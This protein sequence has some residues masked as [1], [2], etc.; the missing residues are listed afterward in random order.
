MDEMFIV[1][2]KL[3]RT[4]TMMNQIVQED[5]VDMRYIQN[6]GSRVLNAEYGDSSSSKP[7][8]FSWSFSLLIF[9]QP[10]HL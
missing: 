7:T 2:G 5:V 1:V 6:T 9:S 3:G 8:S 10:N 4:R